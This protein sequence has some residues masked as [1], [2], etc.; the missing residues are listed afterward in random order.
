VEQPPKQVP[1]TSST[2]STEKERAEPAVLAIM[3]ALSRRATPSEQP[4]PGIERALDI[5]LGPV[6]AHVGTHAGV[7]LDPLFT[8]RIRASDLTARALT[9]ALAA[10]CQGAVSNRVSAK[11]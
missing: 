5:G 1:V 8:D 4:A 7:T 2:A 6:L 11:P 9:A 3:R 10:R